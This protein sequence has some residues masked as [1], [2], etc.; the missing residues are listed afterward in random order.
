M[1]FTVE[2][3][4]DAPD[5]AVKEMERALT[6]WFHRPVKVRRLRPSA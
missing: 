1:R 5:N 4:T 3:D 2:L 6:T